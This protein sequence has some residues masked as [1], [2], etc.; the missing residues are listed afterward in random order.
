MACKRHAM[1]RESRERGA[2][3]ETAGKARGGSAGYTEA[4]LARKKHAGPDRVTEAKTAGHRRPRTA[5]T[6]VLKKP[7]D[8]K[9]RPSLLLRMGSDSHLWRLRPRVVFVLLW[10]EGFEGRDPLPP[11]IVQNMQP[12]P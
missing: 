5:G 1:D 11:Q 2:G 8:Y 12:R 7:R 9:T 4:S 3:K 6:H 10:D